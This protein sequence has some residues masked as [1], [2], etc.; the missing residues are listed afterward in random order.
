MANNKWEGWEI[1]LILKKNELN[2]RTEKVTNPQ[3]AAEMLTQFLF[4]E[5]WMN[6]QNRRAE[7]NCYI[8]QQTISSCAETMFI[9]TVTENE[10]N[11][12]KIVYGF[13]EISENVVKQCIKYIKK[14]VT[15]ICNLVFFQTG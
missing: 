1:P 3:N 10:E 4:Q 13:D 12:T 8:S 7:T 15:H 14:P 5:L 6:F 2:N 11:V 9:F